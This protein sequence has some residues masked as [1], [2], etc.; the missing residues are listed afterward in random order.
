V[1]ARQKLRYPPLP[2]ATLSLQKEAITHLR[3]PGERMMKLAEELYQEGFISYPRTETDVFD[4]AYDLKVRR[5]CP[6]TRHCSGG[7]ASPTSSSAC[8]ITCMSPSPTCFCIYISLTQGKPQSSLAQGAQPLAWNQAYRQAIMQLGR[9]CMRI[10]TPN[11]YLHGGAQACG[12]NA[13]EKFQGL[14]GACL[15]RCLKQLPK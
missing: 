15:E 8:S 4:P 11:L 9:C 3:L 10:S 14:D 2:L 12:C 6:I 7:E 13:R 5:S 1:D